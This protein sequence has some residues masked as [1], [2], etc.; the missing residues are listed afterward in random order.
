MNTCGVDANAAADSGKMPTTVITVTIATR[1]S[2]NF[3]K[4]EKI[5][6]YNGNQD[7]KTMDHIMECIGI[8]LPLRR[9]RIV[10]TRPI[11]IRIIIHSTSK[12]DTRNE[13]QNKGP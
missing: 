11:R 5:K 8:S 9:T 7:A 4:N 13:K 3:C 2:R 12:Q 6:L 10:R 1:T